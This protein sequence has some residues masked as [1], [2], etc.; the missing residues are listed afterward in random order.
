M[1]PNAIEDYVG[2]SHVL[3]EDTI[4]RKLLEKDEVPSMVLWGPPGCGKVSFILSF[5]H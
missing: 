1:R 5:K 4:L 3:G 2:Q